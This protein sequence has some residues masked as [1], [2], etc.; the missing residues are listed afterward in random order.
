MSGSLQDVSPRDASGSGSAAPPGPR[1]G[2]DGGPGPGP[3]TVM[4][5][6][7]LA[8]V[9]LLAIGTGPDDAPGDLGGAAAVSSAPEGPDGPPGPA[10]VV[11]VDT[12]GRGQGLGQLLR[13]H[14]LSGTD[15]VGLLDRIREHESPRRLQPGVEVHF[16]ARV[17]ETTGR[18]VL[19]LDRDR[20]LHLVRT[21]GGWEARL[22]SVPVRVDTIRIGGV[23]ESSLWNASLLGDTRRLAENEENDILDRITQVFA[24]QVDFFRD[25]RSGD[26]FRVLIEREVRPDGSIRRARVLA[27]EFFNDGRRLPAVRFDVPDAPVEYYDEE[28]EATRKAF[29]RAPL[30]YGRRTSGFTRRRFH[31]VLKRYRAHRGV[32]YGARRGTP[33]LA[34]GS[35]VVTRARWWG[36]YGRV[37]EIRHNSRHRTRYAHLSGFARGVRPGV[38]VEQKEVIGYVGASGLATGS[39]V[40]Y[41]FLV[42]GRQRN[43]AAVDLPPGDPVPAGHREEYRRVRDRRLSLLRELDLPSSVRVVRRPDARSGGGAAE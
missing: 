24:W 9:S 29:L 7:V 18:V 17:P 34:T 42:N 35:G 13:A 10:E 39:H 19:D 14:G 1:G 33:V 12:L 21:G 37:V 31:P 3:L 32:D 23:I 40:H 30:E 25:I 22:D 27:A 5:V 28:G 4:A 43:P 8:L 16:A 41:E 38:R 11:A 36:G 26:A 20:S 2:G 6:A 15:F